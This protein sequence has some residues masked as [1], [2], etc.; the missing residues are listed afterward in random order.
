MRK[1]KKQ[2]RKISLNKR[3]QILTVVLRLFDQFTSDFFFFFLR[4][5]MCVCIGFFILYLI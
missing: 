2:S 1:G 5:V 3:R 4:G